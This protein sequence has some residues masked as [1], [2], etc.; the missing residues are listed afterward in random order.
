MIDLYTASTPNGRKISIMLE[1]CELLYRVHLVNLGR[2]EQ[3]LPDFVSINPN[4]KI[5]AI[6]DHD[7]QGEPVRV[8]ESGAVLI[9]LAQKAGRLLPAE[10]AQHFACLS[11]LFWQVA[12]VGPMFG[13]AH[14]FA[15]VAPEKLGYPINRFS[16]EAARLVRLMDDHLGRTAFLAGEYSIADIA[17]FPWLRVALDSI[18]QARSEVT[19]EAKH[20]RRW[21]AE[22]AARPAVE[23]GLAV[24]RPSPT[25]ENAR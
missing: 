20:V 5:P 11:W 17:A 7:P 2:K 14:H 16:D 19:G 15:T 9:Y 8:F 24:G 13:Q 12:N 23:R 4:S 21:L 10:P 6:V 25:T 1:E 22:I 3:F 18:C